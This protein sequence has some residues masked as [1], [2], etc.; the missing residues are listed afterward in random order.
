VPGYD[1]PVYIVLDDL[2][3]GRAYR[4]TAEEKADLETVISDMLGGEYTWPSALWNLTRPRLGRATVQR[5]SRGK[6]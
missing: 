4:E 5:I 3:F 6:C 1:V 2:K